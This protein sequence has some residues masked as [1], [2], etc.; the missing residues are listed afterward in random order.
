MADGCATITPQA[1][2]NN[3]KTAATGKRMSKAGAL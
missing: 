2:T 3:S 1:R